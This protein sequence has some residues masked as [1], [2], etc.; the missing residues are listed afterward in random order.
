[1]FDLFATS[2]KIHQ[3]EICPGSVVRLS[4]LACNDDPASDPSVIVRSIS[5]FPFPGHQS[6]CQ[7]GSEP[8]T[9]IP[10]GSERTARNCK[11][12]NWAEE[13]FRLGFGTIHPSSTAVSW[14]NIAPAV[15]TQPT[16]KTR[17]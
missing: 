9:K 17:S 1:M 6:Q 10:N 15:E 13:L 12:G 7:S 4:V 3:R 5:H 14:R 11:E 8:P 16:L 2:K